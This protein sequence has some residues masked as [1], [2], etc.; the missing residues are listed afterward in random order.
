VRVNRPGRLSAHAQALLGARIR[1]VGRASVGLRRP[2]VATL[3][4]RLARAARRQL[5]ARGRLR[6]VLAI[7]FS[8]VAVGQRLSLLLR[9]ARR[10]R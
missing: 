6:L 10:E 4:L 5:T 8:R 7:D 9:S 3:T 1:S 2:G